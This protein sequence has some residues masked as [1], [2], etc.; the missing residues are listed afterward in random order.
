M[1]FY[2]QIVRWK[3]V[4]LSREMQVLAVSLAY[5]SSSNRKPWAPL[6]SQPAQ[7]TLPSLWQTSGARESL[8]VKAILSHYL[9]FRKRERHGWWEHRLGWRLDEVCVETSFSVMSQKWE[10]L[11]KDARFNWHVTDSLCGHRCQGSVKL[12]SRAPACALIEVRGW[13]IKKRRMKKK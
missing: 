6:P 11:E 12:E 13:E 1:I 3:P 2:P 5:I 4:L 10:R 8:A 9:D 7:T